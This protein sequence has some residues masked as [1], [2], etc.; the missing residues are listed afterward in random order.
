[1]ERRILKF[2][3][4]YESSLSEK[5]KVSLNQYV[6]RQRFNTS[7][8]TKCVNNITFK[9]NYVISI[10]SKVMTLLYFVAENEK[11]LTTL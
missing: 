11:H 9:K 10:P 3:K 4:S 8:D 6:S 7:I 5:Q 1:V 2:P